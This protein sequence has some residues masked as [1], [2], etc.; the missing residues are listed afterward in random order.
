MKKTDALV[1]LLISN[2]KDI[3]IVNL[4]VAGETMGAVN[5]EL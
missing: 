5:R 1:N 4:S 3:V 2:I